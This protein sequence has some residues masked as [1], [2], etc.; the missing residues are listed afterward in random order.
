MIFSTVVSFAQ[1]VLFIGQF[2][3]DLFLFNLF[4]FVLFWSSCD[5]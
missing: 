2:L 4:C 1:R 3:F 5:D